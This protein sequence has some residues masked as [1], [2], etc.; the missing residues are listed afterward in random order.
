MTEP[1]A[2]DLGTAPSE[3][4]PSDLLAALL[5]LAAAWLPFFPLLGGSFAFDDRAQLFANEAVQRGDLALAWSRGW[6]ANVAGTSETFVAGGDLYR[7]LTT[8]SLLL[9]HALYGKDPSGYHFENLLLHALASLLIWQLCRAWRFSAST[10]WLAAFF[11]A[12]APIAVEPVASIAQ[13]A[14]LLAACGAALALL[15][16]TRDRTVLAATA[17]L[18]ALFAK[19]GAIIVP[20]LALLA[21]RALLRHRTGFA[22]L[23]QRYAPLFL[24]CALYLA[25][26]YAVL[27]RLDLGGAERATYYTSEE[28]PLRAWLTQAPFFWSQV[29]PGALLGFPLV[30]DWSRAAQPT[31]ATSDA[32]AWIALIAVA[33]S[34]V[35][36]LLLARRFPRACFAPLFFAL[37]Y[38]PTANFLLPIGVLFAPRLLYWPHLGSALFLA[39]AWGALAA[40]QRWSPRTTQIAALLPLAFLGLRSLQQSELWRRPTAL[41]AA[42]LEAVPE[43]ALVRLLH[44]QELEQLALASTTSLDTRRALYA[45]ALRDLE[46]AL[47]R[48]PHLLGAHA[49]FLLRA[50]FAAEREER[51]VVALDTALRALRREQPFPALPPLEALQSAPLQPATAQ[52]LRTWGRA[53]ADAVPAEGELA[54]IGMAALLLP[55]YLDAKALRGPVS[56]MLERRTRDRATW[57]NQ[58]ETFLLRAGNEMKLS[59]L[60]VQKLT[61]TLQPIATAE[62][63][64]AL[65]DPLHARA[66]AWLQVLQDAAAQ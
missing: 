59:L 14:E 18:A 50:A 52:A 28:W 41:Y 60:K 43:N 9:S 36:L 63:R 24:A 62:A 1:L 42:T 56:E 5:I 58:M 34:G 3:K 65:L 23:A 13:R 46:V 15:A 11:F 51:A 7:P 39:V 16:L 21:D 8:S 19:E 55:D 33:L 64:I 47:A 66:R 17:L 20:V 29:L 30:Y 26:R 61:E 4:R 54:L 45:Q 44:A 38:L 25:A 12:L 6:W 32:A 57:S 31:A 2:A 48:D 49:A 53:V 10:A 22:G 37:A 35:G 40:R 27:G